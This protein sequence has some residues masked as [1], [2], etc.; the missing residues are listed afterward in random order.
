MTSPVKNS[1]GGTW[2]A[3]VVY[4]PSYGCTEAVGVHMQSPWYSPLLLLN[5]GEFISEV[6]YG[7]W[8]GFLSVVPKKELLILKKEYK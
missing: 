4:P 3:E 2:G 6:D 1:A 8:D 5:G 7:D